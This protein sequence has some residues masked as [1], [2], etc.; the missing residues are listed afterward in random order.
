MFCKVAFQVVSILLAKCLTGYQTARR[1]TMSTVT[2]TIT[3][4]VAWM[5]TGQASII[6]EPLESPSFTMPNVCCSQHSNK[7]NPIPSIAPRPDISHPS[8]MKMLDTCLSFAP[9]LRSVAMSFFFS[10]MSIDKHPMMLKLATIN[11]KVRKIYAIN[12][13]IFIIYIYFIT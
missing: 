4:S 3:M 11:M 12:F 1:P 6:N 10:I 2:N 8:N 13:S 5:L 9:M 7:P